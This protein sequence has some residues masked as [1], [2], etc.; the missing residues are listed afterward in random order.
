MSG[1]LSFPK[2]EAKNWRKNIKRL[3]GLVGDE[4]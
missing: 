4:E 3:R 2:V 1:A